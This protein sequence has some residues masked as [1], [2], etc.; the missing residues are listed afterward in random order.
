MRLK[1]NV[2]IVSGVT[3]GITAETNLFPIFQQQIG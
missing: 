2:A 1:D 3:S